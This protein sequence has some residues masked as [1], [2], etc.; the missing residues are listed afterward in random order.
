[1]KRAAW[2]EEHPYCVVCGEVAT[3]V[4]HVIPLS[5]G[6]ADDESNY[7]SLCKTHHSVKTGRHDRARRRA[8]QGG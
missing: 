8:L 1:V 6:G 5:A 7:Q 2:L 4:D 3:E